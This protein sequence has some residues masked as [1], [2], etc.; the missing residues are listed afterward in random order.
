MGVRHKRRT[1]GEGVG[2]PFERRGDAKRLGTL[3]ATALRGKL[4]QL[5]AG[6]FLSETSLCPRTGFGGVRVMVTGRSRRTKLVSQLP[7]PVLPAASGFFRW[8]IFQRIKF[9]F[10]VHIVVLL[11]FKTPGTRRFI[12]ECKQ[13]GD[14]VLSSDL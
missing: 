2:G 14:L 8:A 13:I 9:R 4:D 10:V 7:N 5:G 11:S 12:R 1:S 6:T 3:A